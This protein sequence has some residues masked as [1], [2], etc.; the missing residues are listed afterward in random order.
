MTM[1][2]DMEYVESEYEYNTWIGTA[3]GKPLGAY[4]A[5]LKTHPNMKSDDEGP[6]EK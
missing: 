5:S 2:R 4:M 3:A 6:V 1:K